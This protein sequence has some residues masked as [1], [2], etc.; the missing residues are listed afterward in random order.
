M[1]MR[2]ISGRAEQGANLWGPGEIRPVDRQE[3]ME[4]KG[5]KGLRS[6]MSQKP[7]RNLKEGA[8]ETWGYWKRKFNFSSYSE[9][10]NGCLK[11]YWG[12]IK[13]F[14]PPNNQLLNRSVNLTRAKRPFLI[15]IAL[16]Q[17]LLAIL[18]LSIKLSQKKQSNNFSESSKWDREEIQLFRCWNLCDRE[19]SFT[20]LLLKNISYLHSNIHIYLQN[21]VWSRTIGLSHAL[22]LKE[23][24]VKESCP[25]LCIFHDKGPSTARC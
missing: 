18:V 25:G 16:V 6:L 3:K 23:S 2:G 19:W 11:E 4:R 17:Y 20:T 10:N 9:F 7:A 24:W 15:F 21:S 22:E 13:H 12:E 8:G 1:E 5:R 14:K